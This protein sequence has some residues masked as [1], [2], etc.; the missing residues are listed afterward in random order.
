MGDVNSSAPEPFVFSPSQ[1]WDGNDGRW[2][3]FIV[4]IGTPEQTFRILPATSGHETFIPLPEGCI[5]SDPSDCG[6]LR[7]A[8]PFNG[9]A[10]NGF[11]INAS[12]T[13]KPIGL[14]SLTFGDKLGM[15]D[16]GMYGFD[17]VGL[18]LPNSGGLTLAGQIVA[19]IATKNFYLGLLGLGPKPSNF[20]DFEYPQPSF[21]RNLKD[22]NKI[23][24][25]S[26]AYTAGAAYRLPKLPGSLTLG[27]YDTARYIANN[28]SF[29]F[30]TDD[31]RV[32][33]VG[34]Q[35]ITALNTLSGSRSFLNTPILSIIDSS[36]P[37]IWLPRETC[38]AFEEAF[39]LTYDADSDLYL[40]N[41]TMHTRLQNLHPTIT[42]SLGNENDPSKLVSIEL[43]YGA[44][45]LQAS[46]PIFGNAT[47]Y[48][49]IRRAANDTQYLLGRTFLQ[50]AYVIADYERSN[51]SV[52]Q[53]LF[54]SRMPAQNI[55]TITVPSNGTTNDSA[56]SSG[57]AKSAIVGISVGIAALVIIL[58][59]LGFFCY[60][61]RR[62]AKQ[63]QPDRPRTP[64]AEMP[65]LT[66][67]KFE[68]YHSHP[69]LNGSFGG[70]ELDA[71]TDIKLMSDDGASRTAEL[72]GAETRHELPAGYG[73]KLT[74]KH[75]MDGNGE[76]IAKK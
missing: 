9:K 35:R 27:G 20:S 22:Q 31:S 7:G 19:G 66:S 3:S 50:E 73:E 55:V 23:P 69:E 48:F 59:L 38:D 76:N 72:W 42:F 29:P 10:S 60:R 65:V 61:R 14:Y 5:E 36:F 62:R 33:S 49:P 70:A 13:W 54:L 44:F 24:S 45:D 56:G 11:A 64:Q 12:S 52:H 15:N 39:G 1:V 28:Q 37:H 17:T 21:M 71:R 58:A 74:A 8:Y 30:S 41:D 68:M 63:N 43:P 2:S 47:R 25:L 40:I 46:H 16:N 53:A 75:E 6:S 67:G 4:R 18:A 32:L 26:F 51:F 34:V 57:L